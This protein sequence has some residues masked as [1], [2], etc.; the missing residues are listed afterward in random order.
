[1]V[2]LI[3]IITIIII[4]ILGL[5]AILWLIFSNN[6]QP[7]ANL[8]PPGPNVGSSQDPPPKARLGFPCTNS[9]CSSGLVCDNGIC[10]QPIGS[11]CRS[12][13]DCDSN[14]AECQFSN[15]V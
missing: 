14:A 10:K 8:G 6:E 15:G 13:A 1:M 12:L 7:L 2:L 5:L 11:R 9:V 4:S 3:V